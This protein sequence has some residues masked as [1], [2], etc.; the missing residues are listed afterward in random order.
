MTRG[1]RFPASSLTTIAGKPAPTVDRG[2][3]WERGHL[4]GRQVS[5]HKDTNLAR[6]KLNL[7]FFMKLKL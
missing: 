2:R 1:V 6:M 4:A 3:P 5:P 7:Y